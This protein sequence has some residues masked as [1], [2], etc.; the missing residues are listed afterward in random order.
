VGQA[1]ELA[2]TFLPAAREIEDPQVMVEALAV[3]ALIEQASGY[4]ETAL[5]LIQEFER[6]TRER[7]TWFRAK[8]IPDL[9]RTC[10]GAGALDLAVKLLEGLPVHARR[11]KLSLLTAQAVIQEAGGEVDRAL[12]AYDQAVEGWD[13]FGYT[14]ELGRTSLGAGR[15]LVRLG[16][17]GAVERLAVARTAF[18]G[19]GAA[20]LVA[21]TDAWVA[22][23]PAR[24]S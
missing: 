20:T 16:K 6:S 7:P 24:I 23:A 5:E 22:R 17:P 3:A 1:A 9:V 15:C 4:P 8:E 19:L 11:H 14:L 21:E 13:A 10:A 12:Q 18:I 2:R